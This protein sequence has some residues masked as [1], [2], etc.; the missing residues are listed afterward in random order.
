MQAYARVTRKTEY[1]YL[2]LYSGHGN[3]ICDG[4]D[5][6]MEGAELRALTGDAKFV[7]YIFVVKNHLAAEKLRQLIGSHD[8]GSNIAIV[9]GN[10]NNKKTIRRVLDLIP[11]SA[12]SFA[13]INPGG[14]QWLYWA[15]IKELATRGTNWQ[16]DKMELLLVFPLEMALFRNLMR[17][18]CQASMTRFYGNQRWE[19]VKRQ[20]LAGK[21]DMAEIKQKL[22]ELFKDGLREL[23]YRYVE[24][25]KPASP[26]R[27]P[28]Y[29]L[30]SASDS[31]SRAKMLKNAWGKAKYLRCELLYGAEAKET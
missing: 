17:S 21:A 12:S 13:F 19:E 7:R 10:C 8:T 16:G 18:E 23:G 1:C 11:R 29:H 9:T 14:Y 22:V 15:T 5:C 6:Y 26:S 30:I 20:K 25:F 4:T 31:G 28:Y 2:E 24:D 27:Q 3:A